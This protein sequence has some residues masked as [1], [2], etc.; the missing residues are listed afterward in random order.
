MVKT[1]EKVTAKRVMFKEDYGK[2]KKLGE[3]LQNLVNGS[4]RIVE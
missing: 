1:I 4:W 3:M 2:Q